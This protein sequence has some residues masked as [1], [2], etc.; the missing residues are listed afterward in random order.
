[1]NPVDLERRIDRA[2]KAVSEPRAPQTLLPSIMAAARAAA[3]RPWYARPWMTWPRQW[4]AASAAVALMLIAGAS[5]LIPVVL[6]QLGWPDAFHATMR[7]IGTFFSRLDVVATALEILSRTLWQSVIGVA[8]SLVVLM[9][10]TTV[11]VGAAI[12]RVALGGAH[13]S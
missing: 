2:L 12:G 13:Q 4:Q 1:M 7:P 3:L 6:P 5:L 10:G 9:M 11:A 8:L